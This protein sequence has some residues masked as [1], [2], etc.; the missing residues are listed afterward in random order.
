MIRPVQIDQAAV[1]S[2]LLEGVELTPSDAAAIKGTRDSATL[3]A[4]LNELE[5]PTQAATA[6]IAKVN[7]WRDGRSSLRAIDILSPRR[8]KFVYFDDYDSM[9]GL[10]SIPDLVK[11]RDDEELTRSEQAVVS[12][13]A[14]A[15]ADLEDFLE[16]ESHEHLVRD[17][18]NASNAISE[19]VFEYW[20]QNK[21][22]AVK[23]RLMDKPDTGAVPPLNK[24]PL[25]QI[26]G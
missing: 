3:L 12:L 18:E 6:V 17:S 1:V 16:P 21:Q 10:V 11:K 8:P 15:G 25:L 5:A 24:A 14:A 19:E 9:P 13:L 2:H 22:L 20:S 7:S 4:K 26:R 23:I